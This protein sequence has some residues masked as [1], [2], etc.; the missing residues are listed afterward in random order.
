MAT[1]TI[2][3][4]IGMVDSFIKN[5]TDSRESY[6]LFVGKPDPWLDE[7]GAPD[8]TA[9]VAANNSVAQH[10]S[11]IYDDMVFG[12]ILTQNDVIELIPRYNWANNTVYAVYDQNDGDLYSKQF[13]V[14]NDI[15]EVYKCID[16]NY[17]AASTVKPSLTSTDGTFA[18]SDGY[19][20]KYMYTLDSNKNYK[21]SSNNYIP[22]TPNNE[23]KDNAV[24]GTIDIIRLANSG[25][26]YEAYY[27]G[28]LKSV[29]KDSNNVFNAYVVGLD[30]NANP[31]NNY[32]AGSSMY[33]NS[34]FGS[35]QIRKIRSYDGLNKL[36]TLESPFDTYV[37]FN[38][39][40]VDGTFNVGNFLTQNVDSLAILFANGYFQQNDTIV[41]SDTNA[42]GVIT[43]ANSSIFR[44]LRNSTN[45]FAVGYPIY[46]TTYGDTLST[47]TVEVAPFTILNITSN[48]AAFTVGE[49]VFQSN[50][51]AN[52]ANGV[53]FSANNT[54]IYLRLVNGSFSN[55]YQVSGVSSSANAV[56]ANISYS[57]TGLLYVYS[58]PGS[59]TDFV[60]EYT[61]N[62]YIRVGSNTA[63]NIRRI[64]AVNSSVI[65]VSNN[66]ASNSISQ[67]HYLIQSAAIVDSISLISASG[68]ITNTNLNGVKLSISNA[69]LNSVQ[70][71]I[72]EKVNMV[73]N[74]NVNQ[75]V[76][77]TVAYANTDSV[78]LTNIFGSFIGGNTFYIRGDSSY[79]KALI[80]SLDSYKNVTI[81]NPT[82][83]FLIG[84]PIKA[85]TSSV[86]SQVGSADVISVSL[87]PNELT[88]YTISPT[89]TITGDGSGALAYSVVNNAVN[90]TN[91]ISKIVV[92]NPGSGYTKANVAITA[93][94]LYGSNATAAAVIS[95]ALGHGSNTYA[96]LGARYVG[97]TMTIDTGG[98]ETYKFPVYGEYRR[99]GIIEN[100]LF[101]D[102][103]VELNAFD[104]VR[105]AITGKSGAGFQEDEIVYQANSQTAGVVVFANNTLIELKNV[106][107]TFAA[108]SKFANNATA[109][110]NIRGLTSNTTANVSTSNVVYF[111]VLSNAEIVTQAN[112]MATARIVAVNSNTEILL[113]DV[114]GDFAANDVIY[115]PVTNAYAN[116]V[117]IYIANGSQE[118]T[119]SFADKFNQTVRIPLTSNT[120]AYQQFETVKQGTTNAYGKV[121]SDGSDIDIVYTNISGGSFNVGNYI[122]SQNTLAN[123]IVIFANSTYLRL[124][125]K[126]G[127][128]YS[129]DGIINNLGITA[130]VSNVFPVLVLND[131]GAENQFT[132]GVLSSN[133]VGQTSNTIGRCIESNVIK[134]P[135][136]IR[137]SGT[138]IYTENIEPFELSNTSK[139]VIKIV[140]KF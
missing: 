28:Y 97:V 55:A 80:N 39:Q 13:Y 84:Q 86:G 79:Q 134:Y 45:S 19:T 57:N 59:G 49:T 32:Y 7:N 34:G 133:I 68:Y 8:D 112:T 25:S 48:T 139:E 74:A 94:A 11:S 136:L 104:R 36:V 38:I 83:N 47:G 108:N 130:T 92:I 64:T 24:G 132:S 131:V 135:D 63:T 91:N 43:S 122:Q 12:K 89:V 124:T 109:N 58:T 99:L 115:D 116:V 73:D 62:Q 46:N 117:A 129:N 65:T 50:G 15:F 9:V 100:V 126:N 42:N 75:S 61:T 2:H 27:S 41:Q 110:D 113:T 17:G 85:K 137:D 21:F 128:F 103:T 5:I 118:V 4:Y 14:V 67:P 114:S 121:I 107:G 44:V 120:G 78:I 102:V 20:W 23:V 10:E 106:R 95:P 87:I 70:F 52:V 29:V 18:T 33:L 111:S 31:F 56:V 93:N 140:I 123:A 16:N 69:V 81:N 35:G 6:Y 76:Y 54:T 26:S 98:N 51:S 77:G 90:T 60:N 37:N 96:E 72:G 82:G 119:S 71:F 138:V 66:F 3:H 88:H 105:L 40:N 22:V 1:L 53:I 125:A 101:D 30:A 127:N